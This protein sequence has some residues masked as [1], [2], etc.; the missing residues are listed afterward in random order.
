MSE[1]GITEPSLPFWFNN[2]DNELILKVTHQN[3]KCDMTVKIEKKTKN[4]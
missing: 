4:I 3:C 1:K 2:M